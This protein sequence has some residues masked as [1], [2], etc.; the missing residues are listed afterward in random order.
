MAI[1]NFLA[2]DDGI[3]GYAAMNNFYLYR[4]AAP[5]ASVLIAWDKDSTF[6]QTDFPIASRLDETC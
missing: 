6:L 3:L 1:E 5:A 4:F 2:E